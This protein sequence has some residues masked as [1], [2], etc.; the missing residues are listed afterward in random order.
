MLKNVIFG[1]YKKLQSGLFN[2][3]EIT[4]TLEH[5]AQA[6][7]SQEI[8]VP[9]KE[10]LSFPVEAVVTLD[11]TVSTIVNVPLDLN[12]DQHDVEMS[13]L[14]IEVDQDVLI[15]DHIEIDVSQLLDSLVDLDK[16]WVERLKKA[17]PIHKKAKLNIQQPIRIKGTLTPQ[18]RN[19]NLHLKKTFELSVAV[20]IKQAFPI[21]T[22]ALVDLNSEISTLIDSPVAVSL[23]GPLSI[24]LLDITIK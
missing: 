19:L 13:H 17:L 20:P 1:V 15:D 10:K 2:S 5:P 11:T 22:T 24:K 8:K 14:A 12:L 6:R 7:I 9:I 4:A 16:L 18:I 21:R 3:M 23:E